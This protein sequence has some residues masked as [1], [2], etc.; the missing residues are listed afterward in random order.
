MTHPP[1]V[2]SLGC[3]PQ[4]CSGCVQPTRSVPSSSPERASSPLRIQLLSKPLFV[5]FG[6]FFL[7][8][9]TICSISSV[10]SSI[11]LWIRMSKP[12]RYRAHCVVPKTALLGFP[13]MKLMG[14]QKLPLH[15]ISYQGRSWQTR[16]LDTSACPWQSLTL[17]SSFPAGP[18]ELT[19]RD[20]SPTLQRIGAGKS[21]GEVV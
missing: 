11:C 2:Q 5:P 10:A 19:Q 14:S 1:F 6:S 15:P 8:H 9:T 18:T 21:C 20:L 7:H 12:F 16:G 4:T 3:V 17:R 13:V